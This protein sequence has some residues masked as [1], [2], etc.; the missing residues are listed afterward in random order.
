MSNNHRRPAESHPQR[1][2]SSGIPSALALVLVLALLAGCA[3]APKFAPACPNLRLLTDAGDLASFN[4]RGQDVTN[5]LVSARIL[6]IPAICKP[7]GPGLT[8]ATMHVHLQVQRGPALP[9]RVTR[10]PLFVTIMDGD[11]V[12]EQQDYGLNVEFPA[13]VDTVI[14]DTPDID[15]NFPISTQKSAAA[16]TIYV[17]FRLTPEQLQYNRRG[18][19]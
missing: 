16:Y 14:I 3:P 7:G 2:N 1:W 13:N 10:V 19:G 9:G 12:R 8:A 18:R 6:A 11:T 15:M 17:G 5:L 4:G